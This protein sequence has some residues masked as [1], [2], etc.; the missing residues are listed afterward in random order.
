MNIQIQTFDPARDALVQS[1]LE[2]L[3]QFKTSK[4]WTDIRNWLT[5]R[6]ESI[7][8]ELEIVADPQE[9][10]RLQGAAVNVRE[11]LLI[12]DTLIEQREAQNARQQ[13]ISH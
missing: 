9:V 5:E 4:L 6:Q 13:G 7:R 8:T 11:L 12:V 1:S 10:W 2:E 3:Q